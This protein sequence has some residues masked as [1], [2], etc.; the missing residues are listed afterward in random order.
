MKNERERKRM[1][2]W[3]IPGSLLLGLLLILLIRFLVV[4]RQTEQQ[5]VAD[6]LLG[7]T[8]L[9]TQQ[10]E[11]IVDSIRK[12]TDL[13]ADYISGQGT[14]KLELS[15][16]LQAV[17]S[18]T[19]VYDAVICDA[20]G[21][22]VRS[23]GEAV[24]LGTAAYF[25]QIGSSES[26]ILYVM[27]DGLHDRAALLIVSP[28]AEEGGAA[29]YVL[30]YYDPASFATVLKKVN[31]GSGVCFVLLDPEGRT[32]VA[33][34]NTDSVFCQ[35]TENYYA[36][37]KQN[38]ANAVAVT[39]MSSQVSNGISGIC[40]VSLENESRG[41]VYV[42]MKEYD[43]CLLVCVS[44]KFINQSIAGEWSS[45]QAIVW[46]V[47]VIIMVLAG[48]VVVANI[49]TRIRDN[50]KSRVLTDKADTDLLTDLYNKAA[51]ERKIREYLAAHPDQMGLLFV[52]DIDNFKKINDTMGHAFG[53]EVLRTFGA[54]IRAEFRATDILGRT[55]GDEFTIFL[56]NMKE[57]GIIHT[58]AR[59]LERFF[60]N[61]QAGEYVKYSATASIGAA[62]YPRDGKDFE[63]LYK[64]A[65]SALY[66]A[67]K[68][69][70]NQLAF[71]GDGM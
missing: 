27:E 23:D 66:V 41:V 39:K 43:F 4:S 12:S 60:Q 65:D 31:F 5:E 40:H 16:M 63:T 17:R 22:G 62:I 52:L 26:P 28:I 20:T 18:T 70:K 1:L 13:V 38:N 35:K 56:C 8:Q 53:D 46:Q 9:Y 47:I 37:L 64:A 10:V 49:L 30:A 57:E 45:M 54:Q 34:G 25:A 50:E 2:Q 58:E 51:T 14:E 67:K 48:V 42:P 71:Y 3:V 7:F 29:G 68:R 59:R 6:E 44:Q 21:I 33:T 61:F 69:G 15:A 32:V 36:F 55:G 11:S 24:D 19:G